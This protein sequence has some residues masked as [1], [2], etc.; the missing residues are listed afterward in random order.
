MPEDLKEGELYIRVRS[1]SAQVCQV[2][3][4][5]STLEEWAASID[6]ATLIEQCPSIN[7]RAPAVVMDPATSAPHRRDI[8]QA[9]LG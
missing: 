2:C 9:I 3:G 6:P 5:I 4:V 7:C 8:E 1:D